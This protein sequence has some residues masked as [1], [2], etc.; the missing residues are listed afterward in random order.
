L[1]ATISLARDVFKSDGYALWRVDD[2]GQWRMVRS[3]GVSDRFAARIVSH[4]ASRASGSRVPF[5]EPFVCEDVSSAPML[6]EMR[7]A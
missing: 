5:A 3:F 4:A 7:D 2:D 6:S 1:S